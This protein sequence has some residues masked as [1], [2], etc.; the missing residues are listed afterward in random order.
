MN[1]P[2]K[3]PF[4]HLVL[5]PATQ[6]DGTSLRALHE[7]SLRSMSLEHYRAQQVESFIAAGTLD[8]DMID[9][10][11][12]FVA[13]LEGRLVG[14]GGWGVRV[15]G[16]LSADPS[17]QELPRLRAMFVDPANARQGIGSRL[18]AHIE[19]DVRAS[20]QSLLSL[21]ALLSGVA[22]YR[23]L[24]YQSVRHGLIHLPDGEVV[25]YLHM[26]KWLDVA[27]SIPA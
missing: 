4:T 7:R 3:P 17:A 8:A 27:T 21:D 11:R 5:R 9:S 24:G 20:G 23:T 18:V 1:D 15:P 6:A 12:Y 22:L 10:G 14:C 16:Y 13:E 26:R 2:A 25:R 19:S